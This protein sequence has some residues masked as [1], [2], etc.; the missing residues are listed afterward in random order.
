MIFLQYAA[1]TTTPIGK[2]HHAINKAQRRSSQQRSSQQQQ[3]HHGAIHTY[4]PT[5]EHEVTYLRT[6]VQQQSL[7]Q[8]RI[9]IPTVPSTG[10]HL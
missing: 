4:E 8:V 7:L 5:R 1:A 3:Q 6:Y 2:A 10:V 9:D